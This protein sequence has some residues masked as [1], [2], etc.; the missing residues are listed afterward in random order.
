MGGGEAGHRPAGGGAQCRRRGAG[1]SRRAAEASCTAAPPPVTA[2]PSPSPPPS[3]IAGQKYNGNRFGLTVVTGRH[4]EPPAAL[5]PALLAKYPG[6]APDA[7][8]P[9][10]GG[11]LGADM[12]VH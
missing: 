1:R 5:S 9:A 12:Q 11:R 6:L 4:T 7:R 8:L 2:L 3:S 10:T